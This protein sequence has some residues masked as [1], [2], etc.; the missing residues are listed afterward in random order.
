[1]DI[2]L[3]PDLVEFINTKVQNG[4]YDSPD[5]VVTA[6]LRMLAQHDDELA[7]EIKQ[8]NIEIDKGLKSLRE[9]K[10]I[11]AHVVFANLAA[12]RASYGQK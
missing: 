7:E 1:M 10:G 4:G 3:T 2:A 11:P 6:G 9:G 8:L 5:A 12:R